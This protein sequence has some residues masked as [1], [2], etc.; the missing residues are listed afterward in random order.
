MGMHD[1]FVTLIKWV[2]E[3][4]FTSDCL[5]KK[6]EYTRIYKCRSNSGFEQCRLQKIHLNEHCKSKQYIGF[7]KVDFILKIVDIDVISI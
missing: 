4:V 5:R 7:F 1:I 6:L 3:C 2:N